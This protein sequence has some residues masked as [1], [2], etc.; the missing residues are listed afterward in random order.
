MTACHFLPVRV[1]V[2]IPLAAVFFPFQ[3]LCRKACLQWGERF[4]FNQFQDGS[5]LLE[6]DVWV[7]DGR[8]NEECLG[9]WVSLLWVT[10][11]Y[12]FIFCIEDM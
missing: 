1:C 11:L 6:I 8:K 10:L 12:Y 2:S 9:M 5:D 3:N 7:K 4:D